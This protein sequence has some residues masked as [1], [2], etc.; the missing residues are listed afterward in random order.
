MYKIDKQFRSHLNSFAKFLA[1][2]ILAK[3]I[4]V[5]MFQMIFERVRGQIISSMSTEHHNK[6]GLLLIAYERKVDAPEKWLSNLSF[7]I[8]RKH[9]EAIVGDIMEDC[10]ELRKLGK[11]ERRILAHV[12]WHLIIAVVTLIPASV[13]YSLRAKVHPKD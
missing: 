13:I 10:H 11:S 1:W 9:R 3:A 12:I 2:V 5:F 4:V 7:W 8:P 6:Y